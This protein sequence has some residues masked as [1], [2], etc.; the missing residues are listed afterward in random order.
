MLKPSYL[1]ATL[2][3]TLAVNAQE[4]LCPIDSSGKISPAIGYEIKE[5]KSTKNIDVYT[6]APDSENPYGGSNLIW[7]AHKD[8]LGRIV[9]IESGGE[10]PSQKL[11]NF[12]NKKKAQDIVFEEVAK[13]K[14]EK[15][16]EMP[17]KDSFKATLS[18]PEDLPVK[19]GGAVQMTYEG[20]NCRVSEI[21][22]RVYDQKNKR[23]TESTVFSS[24]QCAEIRSLYTKYQSDIN[25]CSDKFKA[26]EKELAAIKKPM[27][28][29]A[30]ITSG[31]GGGG[32]APIRSIASVSDLGENNGHDD[33]LNL[34]LAEFKSK[35]SGEKELC[36]IFLPSVSGPSNG[37]RV[38]SGGDSTQ[39]Q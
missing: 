4:S 30:R 37:Q 34:N 6:L 36:E 2:F 14:I 27:G 16:F 24:S 3:F 33:I 11:L 13:K 23:V 8:S 28:V 21:S 26:H 15:Q 31:V 38:P 12:V 9:K 29:Y 35:I 10:K 39:A 18:K 7:T 17:T 20:K 1:V 22:D 5:V 19:F 25:S 32:G